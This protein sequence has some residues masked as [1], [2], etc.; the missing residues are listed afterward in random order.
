MYMLKK[1]LFIYPY[2]KKRLILLFLVTK[3]G[4]NVV[5]SL[6]R[7]YFPKRMLSYTGNVWNNCHDIFELAFM[8]ELATRDSDLI[9]AAEKIF[10]HFEYFRRLLIEQ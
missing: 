2:I 5:H 9:I 10:M 1:F 4:Y 8:K 7:R 6:W 3:P